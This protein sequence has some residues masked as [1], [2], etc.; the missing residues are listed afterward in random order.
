MKRNFYHKRRR[1][2]PEK[3]E[4]RQ[5]LAGDVTVSVNAGNLSIV[6]DSEDNILVITATANAGEFVI[7]SGGGGTTVN[8]GAVPVT[9]T[10]VTGDVTIQLHDGGDGLELDSDPA[11]FQFPGDLN[12]DMGTNPEPG[13]FNFMSATGANSF[14]IA[15]SV[16]IVGHLTMG[17]GLDN[18]NIANDFTATLSGDSGEVELEGGSVGGDVTITG[19]DGGKSVTISTTVTGDVHIDLNGPGGHISLQGGPGSP[20]H[21]GGSVIVDL[22]SAILNVTGNAATANDALISGDIVVTGTGSFSF[23]DLTCAGHLLVD[24]TGEGTVSSGFLTDGNGMPLPTPFSQIGGNLVIE[25][26]SGPGD[27]RL[28]YINVTNDLVVRGGSGVQDVRL[29]NVRAGNSLLIDTGAGNDIVWVHNSS[30][31]GEAAVLGGAGSDYVRVGNFLGAR[32]LFVE[33]GAGF[34]LVNVSYTSTVQNLYVWLGG[35][36]DQATVSAASAR[37]LSVDAGSGYDSVR[38]EYSAADHLF[39]GLGD[40]NDSLAVVGSL[41]RRSALFD[42]GAGHDLLLSRGNLLSGLAQQNFESVSS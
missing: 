17:A 41:V 32:S 31:Y 4:T 18:A 16:T 5:M 14:S 10:G 35:D 42:G 8:G 37:Y 26:A 13:A 40:G 33:T 6:G 7:S 22:E 30:A 1:F 9:V 3:L 38:I 20:L 27:I 24:L 28:N 19:T 29:N 39:A 25:H 21:I 36:S 15:G 2:G 23:F 34:D 11:A 12:I